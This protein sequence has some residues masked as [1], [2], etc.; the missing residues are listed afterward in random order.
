VYAGLTALL[1]LG[2]QVGCGAR[3]TDSVRA[4]QAGWALQ[5]DGPSQSFLLGPGDVYTWELVSTSTGRTC[6]GCSVEQDA[7]VDL[8]AR[9]EPLGD[10]GEVTLEL[11]QASRVL[12]LSEPREVLVRAAMFEGCEAPPACSE[13]VPVRIR[14]SVAL[15]GSWTSGAQATS[16]HDER[17]WEP[18]AEL[19]LDL[20]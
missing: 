8:S 18:Q 3:A 15:R 1:L 14:S 20:R 7:S 13:S 16:T 5:T 12:D 2:P 9:L 17:G 4:V 10:P 11:G 6:E 19:K